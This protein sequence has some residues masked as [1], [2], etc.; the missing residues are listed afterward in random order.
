MRVRRL[1]TLVALNV[2]LA[3]PGRA[4]AGMPT[5]TLTDVAS[6]RLQTISFFLVV[7][8]ACAWVVKGIWN[9]L[10]SDLPRLPRLTYRKALG[11]VALWGLL[12]L[13]VLTM[14]SG[15]REL[16]TPGAWT[17]QGLT[18]KLNAPVP[19]AERSS[20]TEAVRRDSLG[21]LRAA[22]WA[23]ARAHD[24]RFPPDDS[25]TPE[26]PDELWQLPGPSGMR[27]LYA[28]GRRT[29]EF[30]AVVAYEPGLYGPVRL[31]LSA[32]GAVTL[33]SVDGLRK[34]LEPLKAKAEA[35]QGKGAVHE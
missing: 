24:G 25:A 6:A 31:V 26:V 19:A 35:G 22:L 17:K 13:L 2:W 12:F 27:Y 5:V 14:I 7:L 33:M 21:R 15:A 9:G 28:P 11:L 18:Y 3:V 23:Y 29:G 16:L 32:D 34:A 1:T 8:L 10:R 20:E 4:L 30:E